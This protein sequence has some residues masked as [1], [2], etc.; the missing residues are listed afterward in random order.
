MLNAR[1]GGGATQ[2]LHGDG[3]RYL[4][5]NVGT[6]LERYDPSDNSWSQLASLQLSR[7]GLERS[8]TAVTHADGQQYIYVVGGGTATDEFASVE[9]YDYVQNKWTTVAS[10]QAPRIY[11]SVTALTH[12]DGLQYLYVGG[13]G[14]GTTPQLIEWYS[15]SSN[16]WTT[17]SSSKT[18]DFLLSVSP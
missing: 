1:D 10:L 17:S 5:M 3:K 14:R 16:S 8:V 9:R 4:Y 12:A 2:L 15:P 6:K 11:G 7:A 13:R 18:L